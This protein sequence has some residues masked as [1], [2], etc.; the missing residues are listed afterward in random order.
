M[1]SNLKFGWIARGGTAQNFEDNEIKPKFVIE[2][3]VNPDEWQDQSNKWQRWY[4]SL[5]L[6]RLWRLNIWIFASICIWS[7]PCFC[8]FLL[9]A[10]PIQPCTNDEGC[11]LSVGI[12][13]CLFNSIRYLNCFAPVSWMCLLTMLAETPLRTYAFR[14][15]L[16]SRSK[17]RTGRIFLSTR[18]EKLEKIL[19]AMWYIWRGEGG[20][21]DGSECSN[22][23]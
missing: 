14:G 3:D 17:R 7:I 21:R 1:S 12:S 2:K 18:Y 13:R 22:K 10:N 4:Y 8:V 19:Q 5:Y 16:R 20:K 15:K 9:L 6:Y 23:S 11:A